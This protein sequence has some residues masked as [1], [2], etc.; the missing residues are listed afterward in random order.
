M[1]SHTITRMQFLRGDIRGAKK[2]IRPPWAL[3][4]ESFIERC[5]RCHKCMVACPE[6]IIIKGR[7]GFPEINFAL[8]ECTFCQMCVERCSDDAL[9]KQQNEPPP[10]ELKANVGLECL[11]YQGVVCL[12]CKEQC[13]TRA[14]TM[15]HQSGA[16]AVPLIDH[17]LCSGC[18]ACYQPCPVNAITLERT[19]FSE[20]IPE[21]I[22]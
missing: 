17:S 22:E 21:E 5:S 12:S 19:P 10:W 15:K 14:I 16:V 20:E 9:I 3:H 7:G 2:V 13:D 1:D 8:G 4:E 18:G 6:K 11:T